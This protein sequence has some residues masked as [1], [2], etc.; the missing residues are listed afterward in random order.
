MHPK[1]RNQKP[2]DLS[3]GIIIVF[4]SLIREGSLSFLEAVYF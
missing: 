3:S 1:K 4:D 2:K